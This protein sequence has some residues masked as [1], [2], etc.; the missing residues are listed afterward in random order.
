VSGAQLDLLVEDAESCEDRSLDALE[1]GER[2]LAAEL[3]R[4]AA[5]LRL[6]VAENSRFDRESEQQLEMARGLRRRADSADP[7]T[8]AEKG[9]TG[10]DRGDGEDNKDGVSSSDLSGPVM[11][12]LEETRD[13]ADSRYFTGPPDQ[14]LDDVGGMEELKRKLV[15]DVRKPLE[16]PEFYEQQESGIENGVLF[17]GPPGT[18]KSWLAKCFAGELGW[19]FAD[20]HAS[21]L[22]SKYVNEGAE[23]VQNL[24]D[25]ARDVTPAVIFLDELDA[26]A[27]DRTG[28]PKKTSSER[29]MVNE[30]LQQ[31]EGVQG[32]EVLVVGATNT[33]GDVDKAIQRSERFTQKFFVGPPDKGSRMKILGV[34]LGEGSREVDWNSLE[35]PRL[36]EWTQGFSAADLTSVVRKAA[37]FSAEES[38]EKG[39][40]VPVKY[41]HVKTGLKEV[42]PSF[43]P[44]EIDD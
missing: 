35:W 41:R 40:L 8:G 38:T 22:G 1:N 25:E 3:L 12:E 20:V 14:D 19:S 42:E 32:S 29:K 28:G 17:Y 4:E 16:E 5:R 23:N 13:L 30:L 2:M 18:G 9:S 31:M 43:D 44:E 7:R 24:F 33:L 15:R 11:G 37:R 34:Q 39:E 21:E 27:S 10:S 6:R 36:L 26:V